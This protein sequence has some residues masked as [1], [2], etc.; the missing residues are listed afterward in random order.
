MTPVV[1]GMR[2][3]I[4]GAG[5]IGGTL[6]RGLVAAGHEVAIANSRGPETLR[7]L[8]TEIGPGVRALDAAQAAEFGELAIVAI[9]FG[10]YA[11]LPPDGL[12]GKVVI[13][14]NNYYPERDGHDA[15]L[16]DDRTTSSELLAA[17]LPQS[18]VV[19]AFNTIRWDHLRDRGRPAGDP[20]RI[21]IP[22]AGDDQEAKRVVTGLV[23]QLGFDAV[24]A[25]SLA[26]GRRQQPGAPV[27]GADLRTGELRDRLAA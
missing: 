16:D 9:P 27:Y 20:D 18:Q 22:I 26:D 13:D 2:I 6:A 15:R 1:H 25:G 3:G 17:H 14:A 4:I 19:K 7:E 12:A 11:E 24:D 10:R 8:V 21:G 23:D 5:H